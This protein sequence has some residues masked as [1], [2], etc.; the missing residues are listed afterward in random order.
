MKP[1][2]GPI[3]EASTKALSDRHETARGEQALIE[4]GLTSEQTSSD[5]YA[6]LLLARE[7][8]SQRKFYIFFATGMTSLVLAGA[9]VYTL[10]DGVRGKISDVAES[11]GDAVDDIIGKPTYA[12]SVKSSLESLEAV[13]ESVLLRGKGR[14]SAAIDIQGELPVIGG[15]IPLLGCPSQHSASITREGYVEVR[16]VNPSREQKAIEIDAVQDPT[17]AYQA[18]ESSKRE[19]DAWTV[20]ARVHVDDIKTNRLNPA[21]AKDKDGNPMVYTSSSG[22]TK[23]MVAAG[24]VLTA[25]ILNPQGTGQRVSLTTELADLT[26]QKTCGEEETV[27]LSAAVDLYTRG[28]LEGNAQILESNEEYSDNEGLQKQAKIYHDLADGETPVVVQYFKGRGENAREIKLEEVKL[29][30]IFGESLPT[31]AELEK[32]FDK[33]PEDLTFA[34]ASKCDVEPSAVEDISKLVGGSSP[35]GV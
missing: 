26:L 33:D 27:A 12:M 20:I 11:V 30:D 24:T 13:D 5:D 4:A 21:T 23:L 22:M 3:F 16:A 17:V 6:K 28:I 18:E 2:L 35:K 8:H 15:C 25:G 14:A 9:G 19:D 29:H 31:E 1:P 7:K 32:H 10:V 34:P